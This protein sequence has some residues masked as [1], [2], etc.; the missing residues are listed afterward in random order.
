MRRRPEATQLQAQRMLQ[1]QAS[2]CGCVA[3][4]PSGRVVRRPERAGCRGVPPSHTALYTTRSVGEQ[5][6]S[7]HVAGGALLSRS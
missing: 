1:A 2:P 7:A 6:T 5:R 4:W 3:P